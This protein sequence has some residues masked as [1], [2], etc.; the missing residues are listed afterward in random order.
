MAAKRMLARW[1]ESSA[2]MLGQ[3]LEIGLAAPDIR[4]S[5]EFYERLGFGSAVTGDLWSHHY[6]VMTC[7]DLCLG[8]HGLR[9]PSPW[10]VFARA[11]VAALAREL[12]ARGLQVTQARLG[13]DVFNEL[14]L[15]D[16]AG[17]VLRVLEARS[18]SPP[19]AVPPVTALGG[20]D[21]LS[22][23]LRDFDAAAAFWQ[24]LGVEVELRDEPWRQLRIVT[25]GI[26]I[27][28]HAPRLHDEP[29]L[30]FNQQDLDAAQS[31]LADLGV[32]AAPGL[33]GFGTPDHRLVTSPEGMLITLLA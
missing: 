1:L 21:S 12:D 32:S 4:A 30:L 18:F 13:D 2:S 8:L 3:V 6:G 16:P 26:S 25:P 14:E 24:A 17:L 19:A 5:C 29:L 27:A 9:R 10:L 31:L 20:F 23:P 28:Y 15:R 11:D 7:R 22:L 33:G